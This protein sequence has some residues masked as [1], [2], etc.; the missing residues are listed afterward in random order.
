MPCS[1]SDVN[2]KFIL[3]LFGYFWDKKIILISGK[4]IDGYEIL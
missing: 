2:E 1:I 4:D 3:D